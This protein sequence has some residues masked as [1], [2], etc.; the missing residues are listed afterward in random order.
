MNEI[1]KK[2]TYFDLVGE[3]M[4]YFFSANLG[5]IPDFDFGIKNAIF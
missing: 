3:K 2:F 4:N 1:E 5:E